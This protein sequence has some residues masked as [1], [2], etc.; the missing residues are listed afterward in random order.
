MRLKK[1]FAFSIAICMVLTAAIGS[2]G[3]YAVQ[4]DPVT[5]T[6]GDA[7]DFMVLLGIMT[8]DEAD[9]TDVKLTRESFAVYAANAMGIG[10]QKIEKRYFA[11]VENDAFSV[12]A[13]GALVEK[14]CISVSEDHL[15]YPA[16]EITYAQAL[17]I[18]ICALGGR[19]YAEAKG[20]FPT[21]YLSAA[22][23]MG[24]GS[25]YDLNAAIDTKAAAELLY[26][27]LMLPMIDIETI[28]S[29]KDGD[30]VTYRQSD[31]NMLSIYHNIKCGNGVVETVYGA[32]INGDTVENPN[33]VIISGT[34][35]T[36]SADSFD[37]LKFIGSG[38]DFFYREDK[39]AN[40]R[41]IFYIKEKAEKGKERLEISIDDFVSYKNNTVTYWSGDKKLETKIENPLL[42]YNGEE[43]TTKVEDTLSKLNKGYIFLCD[44]DL[45]GVYDG[46]VIYDF[47]N[48]YVGATTDGAVYNQLI[49]GSA[50]DCKTCTYIRV[51][52]DM[53]KSISFDDLK[54]GDSL[55]LAMSKSGKSALIYKSAATFN[56]KVSGIK[57]GEE[58]SCSIND[59]DYEIDKSYLQ[60]FKDTVTMGSDYYYTVDIFGKIVYVSAQQS[61]DYKTAYIIKIGSETLFDT[62]L[63]FKMIDESGKI[64][65]YTLGD[66]LKLDGRT[67]RSGEYD[68]VKSALDAAECDLVVRYKSTDENVIYEMDTPI[69]DGKYESETNTITS[70]MGGTK[71]KV[72]FGQNMLAH[73]AIVKTNVKIFYV[74]ADMDSPED[75]D[76]I[77]GTTSTQIRPQYLGFMD[78]F[79]YSSL[80]GYADVGIYR[81]SMENLRGNLEYYRDC[82]VFDEVIEEY[83]TDE[84]GNSEIKTYVKVLGQSG[85]KKYE[86]RDTDIDFSGVDCGDVVVFYMDVN[87]KIIKPKSGSA[88]E[89]RYDCDKSIES[90]QVGTKWKL[91]AYGCRLYNEVT[92]NDYYYNSYQ[93]SYGTAV[94]KTADNVLA[95]SGT[96]DGNISELIPMESS[97]KII[98]VEKDRYGSNTLRI[99]TYDDIIT[100]ES[101]GAAAS[102]IVYRTLE[103]WGRCMVVYN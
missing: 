9:K 51:F 45:N 4:D 46:V 60:T 85:E 47:A 19:D 59:T 96:C 20:G 87:N 7:L 13:I 88:V 80:N 12:N 29:G 21:G 66:R 95:L 83:T 73:K 50:V 41:D 49:S 40:T 30:T 18:L 31:E 6:D 26:K 27:A 84:N 38:A 25:V 91:N 54:N 86:V 99:G 71:E 75:E 78:V 15:F 102:N 98:V 67:Y 23:Q 94:K 92:A 77:V 55:S 22:R 100:S 93:L 43:L 44:S 3:V 63:T 14:G 11:D 48:F 42:L 39:T 8:R 89:V 103:N 5:L 69:L 24:F 61:T 68:K 1:L 79:N 32:G 70:V 97:V 2:L 52:D 72:W 17:K 56:G 37:E 64:G 74:P 33:E 58:Y 76:Y 101:A 34:R 16:D 57:D 62:N 65:I 53:G 28:G 81:Y 82:M 36:I 90:Q 10:N 35:Y